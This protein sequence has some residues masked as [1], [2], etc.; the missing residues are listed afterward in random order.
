MGTHHRRARR[1]ARGFNE[2]RGGVHPEDLEVEE[3]GY[4]FYVCALVIVFSPTISMPTSNTQ[5]GVDRQAQL[6]TEQ[7][8]FVGELLVV[9]VVFISA[10]QELCEPLLGDSRF[11]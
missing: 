6:F 3:R 9:C 8:R 11:I 7:R 2:K 4:I 5:Y 1:V 10:E